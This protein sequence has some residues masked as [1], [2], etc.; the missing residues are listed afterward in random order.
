MPSFADSSNDKGN[1]WTLS[2]ILLFLNTDIEF[3]MVIIANGE[4]YLGPETPEHGFQGDMN[5]R[6]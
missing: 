4:V 1:L 6:Q 5:L 2:E 3:M